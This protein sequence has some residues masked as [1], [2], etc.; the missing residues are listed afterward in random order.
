MKL[1]QAFRVV[2]GDVVAFIGA[3]GKTTALVTLG[4]ELAELGWRVLATTTTHVRPSELDLMPALADVSAPS[5]E[6]ADKLHRHGFVFLHGE[7]A[8]NRVQ[9][10]RP[11]AVANLLDQVDSDVLLIEADHA[12]GRLLKAPGEIDDD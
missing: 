9:G 5:D 10:I 4:H 2:R 3:G 12:A 7:I 6:V 1:H 8:D 11:N